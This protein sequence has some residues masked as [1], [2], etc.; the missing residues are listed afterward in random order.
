MTAPVYCRWQ[1]ELESV[2]IMK[3]RLCLL[4]V[5]AVSLLSACI[6]AP[7]LRNEKFLNDDSL[8][9]TD[10]TCSAPCWRGIT[11]GETKWSDALAILEDQPDLEDPKSE[12][13]QSIGPNALAAVWQPVNGEQCCQMVSED[14]ETVSGIVLQLAPTMTVGELVSAQGEPQYVIGTPGTDDQAI[15]N[16]F[17][18]EHSIVVL[19]FVAGASSGELSESS[20][21]IGI[22]YT[23]PDQMDLGLKLSNLYAWNGYQPFS[24]YAPDKADADY[25]ITQSVTLTPTA[26]PGQ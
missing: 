22:F 23:T 9:K 14:G 2:L 17:Y 19:A 21:V 10:E 16:L 3:L 11:P 1:F 8:L 15:I 4:G 5:F 20:E 7:N 26:T 6:P 18:P 25:A 13:A 12:Q 24:A